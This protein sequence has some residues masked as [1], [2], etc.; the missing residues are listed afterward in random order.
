ML[1]NKATKQAITPTGFITLHCWEMECWLRAP[2]AKSRTKVRVSYDLSNVNRG[3]YVQKL[4]CTF[5]RE[6]QAKTAHVSPRLLVREVGWCEE[7]PYEPRT[8]DTRSLKLEENT[9]WA[10]NFGTRTL[11]VRGKT[12]GSTTLIQ[13]IYGHM[14]SVLVVLE[15]MSLPFLCDKILFVDMHSFLW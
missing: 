13:T 14:T 12:I 15:H 9:I 5:H 10:H 1:D 8:P 11:K 3:T 4:Q 6:K 2:T 7:T